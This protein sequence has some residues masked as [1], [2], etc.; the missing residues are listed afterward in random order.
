MLGGFNPGGRSKP[1]F[2]CSL[3]ALLQTSLPQSLVARLK[4]SPSLAQQP[5]VWQKV[6]DI[7]AYQATCTN[8]CG[9]LLAVGGRLSDL[10]PTSAIH[11]YDPV[12]NSWTV[13]SHLTT[14]RYS[15]LVAVLPGDRLMVVGGR[16]NTSFFGCDVVEIACFDMRVDQNIIYY[17]CSRICLKG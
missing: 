8:L 16:T 12:K 5:S 13:I 10:K 15:S 9:H 14:P 11:I 1:V 2:I 3:S 6:A 17:I 4:T 7:P